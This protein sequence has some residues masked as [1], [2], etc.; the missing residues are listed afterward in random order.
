[1]GCMDMR[2]P[3]GGFSEVWK[4]RNV[5]TG[6]LSAIKVVFTTRPGLSK[7]QVRAAWQVGRAGQG[8]EDRGP[9][10]PGGGGGGNE[11]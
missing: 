6:Q 5:L 10:G 8:G 11:A 1:M 7:E 9:R 2:R 4:A 3:Q